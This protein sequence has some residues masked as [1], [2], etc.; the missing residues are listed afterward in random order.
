MKGCLPNGQIL[1]VMKLFSIVNTTSQ[2]RL[3]ITEGLCIS[4][5]VESAGV[6]SATNGATNGAFLNALEF[7]WSIIWIVHYQGFIISGRLKVRGVEFARMSELVVGLPSWVERSVGRGRRR[8]GFPPGG[9]GRAEQ[10]FQVSKVSKVFN[11]FNVFNV[12]NILYSLI[13]AF[14]A[15][16]KTL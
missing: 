14:F 15:L 6:G 4:K 8:L 9:R 11:V 5:L 10:A 13:S 16:Y 2:T 7:P 3:T 1:L 12:T